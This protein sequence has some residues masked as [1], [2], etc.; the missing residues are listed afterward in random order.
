M[1]TD[2]GNV[3]SLPLFNELDDR[4]LLIERR[5]N[6]EDWIGQVIEAAEFLKSEAPRFGGQMMG[7]SLTPYVAGQPFRIK[8]L[9]D[10]IARLAGDPSIWLASAD[11]IAAA[12]SEWH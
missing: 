10:L 2:H 6:E 11:D 3:L 8:A 1:R 12:S 5:Q 7:F 4:T 9:R